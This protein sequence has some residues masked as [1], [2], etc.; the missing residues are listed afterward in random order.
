ANKKGI[1]NPLVRTGGVLFQVRMTKLPILSLASGEIKPGDIFI[2]E[3][4]GGVGHAGFVEKAD[5]DFIYT[6]EGNPNGEG[7]REGYEV[8]RRKRSRSTI[9][10]FI[11]LAKS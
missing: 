8:A 3:F 5:K 11:Q 1:L 10:G 6:I 2:M 9:K 7:S 4:A